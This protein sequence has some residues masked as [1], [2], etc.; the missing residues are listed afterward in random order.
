MEETVLQGMTEKLT[1]IGRY[2]E[3]EMNVGKTKAMRNSRQPFPDQIKIHLKQLEN[4]DH[5]NHLDSMV[6]ND[7][8]CT[9]KIQSRTTMANA[10][11]NKMMILFPSKL[12]LNL[13]KKLV[14][15]YIWNLA[16]CGAETWTLQKVD[17]KYL[18]SSEM[19]CWRRMDK[20]S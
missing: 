1:E 4:M 20:I 15:Y 11:F 14:K 19:W 12:D 17:Q 6:T 16:L 5:F 8:R 7:A 10:A 13:R 18:G 3:M 9:C 2:Y